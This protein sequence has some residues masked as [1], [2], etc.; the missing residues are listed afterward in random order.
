MISF[1]AKKP[2]WLVGLWCSCVYISSHLF[3]FFFLDGNKEREKAKGENEI[4]E[5]LKGKGWR[6]KEQEFTKKGAGIEIGEFYGG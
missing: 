2:L 4:L 1:P 5:S 3:L 6:R